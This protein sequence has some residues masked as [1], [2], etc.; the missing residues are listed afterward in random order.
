MGRGANTPDSFCAVFFQT[1]K[2]NPWLFF[3]LQ[4]EGPTKPPAAT[5]CTIATS[6]CTS[7]QQVSSLACSRTS[8]ISR[9]SSRNRRRPGCNSCGEKASRISNRKAKPAGLASA[10][11]HYRILRQHSR[12]NLRAPSGLC[13]YGR[14]RSLLICPPNRRTLKKD[15]GTVMARIQQRRQHSRKQQRLEARVTPEQKRL[16]ER[17]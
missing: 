8:P 1:P 15:W 4:K 10:M 7:P 6:F 9:Q 14:R 17:P 11:T 2:T 12:K 16:I 3:F 5:L 13:P